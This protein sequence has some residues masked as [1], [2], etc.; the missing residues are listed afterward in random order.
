M[1]NE[2]NRLGYR[3]VKRREHP[4]C[5][6]QG[7]V[8]V[9]RLVMEKHIGRYLSGMEV[10]HH[11]NGIKNDNRIENLYL[12]EDRAEHARL[13]RN[14]VKKNNKWYKY[15]SVCK[16]E[17]EVCDDN[18]PYSK[19]KGE[20]LYSSWCRNC[21]RVKHNERRAK[22]IEFFRKR[23]KE[24]FNKMTAEERKKKYNRKKELMTEERRLAY[25]KRAHEYYLKKRKLCQTKKV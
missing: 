3:A 18:F 16:K 25:K 21:H 11:I 24:Y 6:S 22:N 23:E 4:F 17:L 13:H 10:V 5:D 15:C 9:H 2:I 19:P 7:N 14:W 8:M 12:C 20:K 1:K